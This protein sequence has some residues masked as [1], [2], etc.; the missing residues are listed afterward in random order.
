MG[1]IIHRNQKMRRQVRD[2]QHYASDTLG[3]VTI[4][5]AVWIVRYL[6]AD[7]WRTVALYR[8]APPR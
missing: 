4:S 5:R 6:G 3:L 8:S 7:S 1:E 2:I